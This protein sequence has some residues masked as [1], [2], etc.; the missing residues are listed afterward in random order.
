MTEKEKDKFIEQLKGEAKQWHDAYE[1]QTAVL[2]KVSQRN[3]ELE[4][5]AVS[6]EILQTDNKAYQ[7]R[8]KELEEQLKAVNESGN[9]ED[10]EG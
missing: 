3:A 6:F 8:I 5:M 9:Q 2:A 1:A 7:K 4:P 10:N